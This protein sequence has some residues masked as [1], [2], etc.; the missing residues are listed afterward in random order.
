MQFMLLGQ[1]DVNAGHSLRKDS[2]NS[3]MDREISE[4]SEAA[5]THG[6]GD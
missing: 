4:I 1:T 5:E 3:G 2:V 6:D